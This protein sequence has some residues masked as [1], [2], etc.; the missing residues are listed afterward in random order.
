M[1]GGTFQEERTGQDW[2]PTLRL[3]QTQTRTGVRAHACTN[4]AS[5]K[6]KQK[7][8]NPKTQLLNGREERR[9][10]RRHRLQVEQQD[11]H[12]CW[13]T[14]AAAWRGVGHGSVCQRPLTRGLIG[15]QA[16]GTFSVQNTGVCMMNFH[17]QRKCG[18]RELDLEVLWRVCVHVCVC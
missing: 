10:Q 4:W 9:R 7:E 3:H 8:K 6:Q 1:A 17:G 11:L 16:R 15:S 14:R 5:L 12:P 13:G 18:K 2:A